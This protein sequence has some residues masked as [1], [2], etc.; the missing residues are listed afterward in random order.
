MELQAQGYTDYVKD[1]IQNIRMIRRDS[2][3][4]SNQWVMQGTNTSYDNSTIN[5]SWP[6]LKVID[7]TGGITTQGSRFTY[8]QNNKPPV[9][10][11]ALGDTTIAEGDSVSFTYTA[12]DPDIGQT[13][14]LSAVTLPTGATFDAATG[15]FN[16][17]TGY[18]SSGANTVTIRASDGTDNTD[19]TVT[20]TVTN[21]NQNPVFVNLPSD[22]T[23]VAEG[24]VFNFTVTASDPDG[25]TSFTYSLVAPADSVSIVDSTGALSIDPGFG[26]AGNVVNYTLR[27]ADGSG[28]TTDTTLTYNVTNTNRAPVFTTAMADTSVDEAAT[29]TLDF[30][31]NSSDPDG[32]T[33]IHIYIEERRRSCC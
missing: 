6:V 11:A 20:I 14:T 24:T 19:T 7:A 30:G 31:A 28:G 10:T 4:V 1:G 22:T 2:G 27:V 3:N 8:S 16:W 15:V 32:S 9:F 17:V 12:T 13:A 26:D 23:S 18:T 33:D 5:S 21:V 25:T 29:L